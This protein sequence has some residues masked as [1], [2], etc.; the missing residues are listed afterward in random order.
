MHLLGPAAVA[1]SDVCDNRP[2]SRLSAAIC[3]FKSSSQRLRPAPANTSIRGDNGRLVSSEWSSIVS[4]LPEDDTSNGPFKTPL[5]NPKGLGATLTIERLKGGIKRG[6]EMLLI[7]LNED[8]I[9]R[10]V[11]PMLLEKYDEWVV[12]RARYMT[13]KTIAPG[14][15]PSTLLM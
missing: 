3:A 15:R 6:T 5:K 14:R 13:L 7:F 9:V 2:G 10:L 12:R 1:T 8:V 11:G 4:T